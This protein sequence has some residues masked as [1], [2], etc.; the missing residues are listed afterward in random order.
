MGGLSRIMV[1]LSVIFPSHSVQSLRL[2]RTCNI[3][4]A[5]ST[6]GRVT[7]QTIDTKIPTLATVLPERPQIQK[8]LSLMLGSLVWR[9]NNELTCRGARSHRYANDLGHTPPGHPIRPPCRNTSRILLQPAGDHHI[10]PDL[11]PKLSHTSRRRCFACILL[12]V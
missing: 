1:V 2:K 5:A 7:T 10:R 6:I 8:I 4:Y 3:A 9:L 12:L 11:Q